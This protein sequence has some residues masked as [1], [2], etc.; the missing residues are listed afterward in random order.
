MIPATAKRREL[1]ALEVDPTQCQY[2]LHGVQAGRC[3]NT[4][5]MVHAGA[6]ICNDCIVALNLRGGVELLHPLE[7][8]HG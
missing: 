1:P 3:T 2:G 4:P 5:S 7:K 8:P 6:S